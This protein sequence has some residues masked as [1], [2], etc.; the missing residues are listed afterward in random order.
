MKDQLFSQVSTCTGCNQ[1]PI[2]HCIECT[3]E[4]ILARYFKHAI[5]DDV[6]SQN[7]LTTNPM[8]WIK[9]IEQK[10]AKENEEYTI[11]TTSVHYF[12]HSQRFGYSWRAQTSWATTWPSPTKTPMTSWAW[13]TFQSLGTCWS[14]ESGLI[15][16]QVTIQ[17]NVSSIVLVF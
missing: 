3:W 4:D 12:F 5:L 14:S 7:E 10:G 13:E 15:L 8:V 16:I 1:L 11:K 17:Y 9:S 6:I 2:Y